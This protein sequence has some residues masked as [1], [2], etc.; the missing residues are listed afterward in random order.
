MADP[1][2]GKIGQGGASSPKGFLLQIGR[3]Q[4]QTDCI[5]LMEDVLLSLVPFRSQPFT[6]FDSLL[7]FVVFG[8]FCFIFYKGFKFT[9]FWYIPCLERHC[10]SSVDTP[11][12]YIKP[13]GLLFAFR[14]YL[15]NMAVIRFYYS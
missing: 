5:A 11:M 9:L 10:K 12:P 13:L 8:L 15:T 3:P 14:T 1:G 4:K 2:R 7:Y 6:R